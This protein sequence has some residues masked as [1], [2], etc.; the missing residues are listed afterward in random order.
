RDASRR[1]LQPLRVK[2]G[3]QG[4]QRGLATKRHKSHKRFLRILCLFVANFP[5]PI[6]NNIPAND[7]QRSLSPFRQAAVSP[8]PHPSRLDCTLNKF[9]GSRRRFC[10][11]A[12]PLESLRGG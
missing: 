6:E 9:E 7:P 11:H 10:N 1:I 12:C 3:W 4:P 8:H 5:M 2:G